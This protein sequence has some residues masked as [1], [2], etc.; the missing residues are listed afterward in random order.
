MQ[1]PNVK[2]MHLYVEAKGALTTAE[3]YLPAFPEIQYFVQ[4]IEKYFN[5]EVM[6]E[7]QAGEYLYDLQAP[8]FQAA[9]SGTRRSWRDIIFKRG[10]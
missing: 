8:S 2:N 3:Q 7:H 10:N 6:E 9:P 4:C 1:K 5:R